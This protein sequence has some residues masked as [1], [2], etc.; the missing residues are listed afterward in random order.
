MRMAGT[1]I[2]KWA[3]PA[4]A[5]AALAACAAL[6]L[7]TDSAPAA[8]QSS[9]PN[10]HTETAD[11][12]VTQLSKSISC[13]VQKVRARH[14]RHRLHSDRGL[15]K[16][17]NKHAKVMVADDCFSHV[18][19]GEGSLEKRISE[20]GYPDNASRFGFAENTGCAQTPAAMI[21]A[22]LT[23][24]QG[25]RQNLLGKRFRDF[26]VGVVKGAPSQCSTRPGYATYAVLF[27]WKQD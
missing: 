22:W 18:C 6:C 17:A 4:V 3:A 23:S 24:H 27:A 13:L 8:T 7:G 12:T 5:L 16:V 20:S 15:R 10:A 11:A 26:G 14:D 1:K 19:P 2:H 25:H 9:C 21:Q